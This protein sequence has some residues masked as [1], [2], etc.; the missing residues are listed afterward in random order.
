MDAPN[1]PD[2]SLKDA[3]L[4]NTFMYFS[5]RV[6][7]WLFKSARADLVPLSRTAVRNNIH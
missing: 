4:R 3:G 6:S 5:L 7:Q 2:R 1:N